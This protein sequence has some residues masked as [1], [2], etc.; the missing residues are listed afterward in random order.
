MLRTHCQRGKKDRMVLERFS[1]VGECRLGGP[2]ILG[3][4]P[5]SAYLF[6][7]LR[8][9]DF[10]PLGPWHSSSSSAWRT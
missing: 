5:R 1:L 2:C 3:L 10:A 8:G 4:S 9:V 7:T 6:G